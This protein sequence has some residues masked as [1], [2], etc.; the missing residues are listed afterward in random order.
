MKF[1]ST[2]L[3]KFAVVAAIFMSGAAGAAGD[4]CGCET[5]A[6]RYAE[7]ARASVLTQLSTCDQYKSNPTAYS[8]CTAPIYT[9]AQNQYNYV[10]NSAYSAC[11]RSCPL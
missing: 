10:Y 11:S 3:S 8:A 6:A 1:M 9:Q 2:R 5:T 7:Q 4:K